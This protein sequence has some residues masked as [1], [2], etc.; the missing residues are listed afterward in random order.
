MHRLQRAFK[1]VLLIIFS[2]I[3]STV[4]ASPQ[5]NDGLLTGEQN[6]I[7]IFKRS[8]PL[9]VNV[10]NVQATLNTDIATLQVHRS[11]GSGFV[12]N[13]DGYVVTNYHVIRNANK[14]IVTFMPGE[15][16]TA[17]LVG[18]DQA[19]DIA[20]LKL[21]DPKYL[22]NLN[23]IQFP[24]ADSSK[25]QVGQTAIAIGNPFGLDHTLTIGV[26]SALNRKVPGVNGIIMSGLIQTDAA[27]NPGNSGGPLLDSAGRLIGMNTLIVTNSG[28]SV[29]LGFALPSNDIQ[30][31][32]DKIF[33]YV[34][35]FKNNFGILPLNDAA[36]IQLRIKGVIIAKIVSNGIAERAGL[37]GLSRNDQGQLVLGDVIVGVDDKQIINMEDLFHAFEN[38]KNGDVVTIKYVRQNQTNEVKIT[39]SENK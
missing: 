18:A 19:R 11:A 16:V 1:I 2:I 7:A 34:Q 31:I 10:H 35:V 36:A 27:I 33:K 22:H 39:W 26:V 13:R 12:W 9:V 37:R 32:V 30:R 21:D 6:T 38:K 8:S 5:T 29:G 4:S 17:T 24:L 15:N 20:V 14:I 25:L 3:I 23:F 28:T